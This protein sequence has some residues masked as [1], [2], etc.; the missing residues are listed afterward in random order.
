MK[1][2]YL[3]REMRVPT[4]LEVAEILLAGTHVMSKIDCDNPDCPCGGRGVTYELRRKSS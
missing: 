4:E 3:V 1:N 2:Y